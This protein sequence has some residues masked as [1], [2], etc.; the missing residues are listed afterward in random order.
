MAYKETEEKLYAKFEKH[1]VFVSAQ[2]SLLTLDLYDEPDRDLDSKEFMMLQK[3]NVIFGEYQEQPYLLDPFLESLVTPVV[4]KIKS[5]AHDYDQTSSKFPSGKRVERLTLLLYGY[6]KFRARFFP[7]EIADMP[8]AL[9]FML[10]EQG[11][12]HENAQWALRYVM[13]LWLSLVAMI[14]FDLAQFDD[15][16]KLGN[17]ARSL[18]HVGKCYLRKA[19]LER[20]GA[21][22]LLSRLYMRKDVKYAFPEFVQSLKTQIRLQSIDVITVGPYHTMP[23]IVSD[24]LKAIGYLQVV[25]EILKNGSADQVQDLAP[26]YLDIVNAI[27]ETT[28]PSGNTLLRKMRAKLMSR[29][30]TR[31][32]P[33]P[34]FRRR[35]RVLDDSSRFMQ[36]DGREEESEIPDVV[37]T[38]LQSLFDTLQ[39]KDSI[40]RWSAAKGVARIAERLPQDFASQVLDTIM[41]LFTIHSIAG[42]SL[43]DLPAIAES[44]WHGATLACAEMA[45]RGL[46]TSDQLSALMRWISQALCFD[47]RKGSHSIGSNVR[48]AAAYVLWSL[49]RTQN[50][51]SLQPYASDLA[52]QLVTATLFDREIHI[53]RAASAAFQEHVGRTGLFP[54]GIDVLRKTDFYA[55]SGKRNAF[56]VAAPQVAEHPEYRPHLLDH[57]LN[58]V[59]RHWDVGMRELGSQSL[60]V[61][62]EQNL[63]ELGHSTT[64]RVVALLRSFDIAD[65]QGGLLALSELSIA[66]R[67]KVDDHET[68]SHLASVNQEILFG[69]RSGIVTAA[70]CRLIGNAIT[71]T[72]IE[73]KEKSSAPNWRKIIDHGLRYRLE[74]VQEVAAIAYATISK[75]EDLTSDIR[76]LIKDLKS[77]LTI[78]QQNLPRVLGLVDYNKCTGSLDP[79]LGYLLDNAKPSSKAAVEVRRNCYQALP[80]ILHTFIPNLTDCLSPA[81]V[82]TVFGTLLSGLDDYTIDERGDVGSWIRV[83]CVQG[84]TSCIVDLFSVAESIENFDDY[85]PIQKYQQAIA[86]ILKQGVERLDNVR[87]EAGTCFT[88]LLDLAPVR[89]AG[90]TWSLPGL[91]QLVELFSE[92]DATQS[93]FPLLSGTPGEIADWADGTRLFPR[94]VRL[95]GIPE[96]RL[97]VL[98]GL[99]LSL[100]SKTES[101]QRPATTSIAAYAKSLPVSNDNGYTLRDLMIDT[102]AVAQK[103]IT[104][105]VVVVPVLQT[106]TILLEADALRP[107]AD[108]PEGKESLSS[109][110][111]MATRNVKNWKSIQRIQESMK[112]TVNLIA[113]Q[114]VSQASISHLNDFL[115][116]PYP[117]IRADSAE[118]LYLFLQST[119]ALELEEGAESVLLETEWWVRA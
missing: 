68:F 43:Y 37:E 99:I 22:L 59:L 114:A 102:M 66:Y 39:D 103:N 31:L 12:V 33:A 41:D 19:G 5:F 6:I 72:E 85:L 87:S 25:N 44:T 15:E 92:A 61:I 36:D 8:I 71:L 116:H 77:D 117:R 88:R 29:M 113:A 58:V 64:E 93:R 119:D 48:D 56:L 40:V 24:D 108:A 27:S 50:A 104:S 10:M 106:F 16:S 14:P 70:A 57:L 107:L 60:R 13:M 110:L 118:Y 35:G 9:N 86:G 2:N 84:L 26:A 95:L 23:E 67:T 53:R 101:T 49:A 79:A 98:R 46:V 81:L 65:V 4:E 89:S 21:A 100:S 75:R 45:R 3:T 20:D 69:P 112:I 82:Q 78:V 90:H 80:K 83:A 105:N 96:Y 94:A 111:N 7:H 97:S 91:S 47:L 63:P 62:C 30:A 74:D 17:T 32:L 52:R 11:I 51:A 28:T 55:I 76:K 18:E 42:A 1:D 73:L 34:K 38:L 115:V 54:H 109:L